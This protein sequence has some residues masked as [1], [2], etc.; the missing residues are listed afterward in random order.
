[1]RRKQYFFLGIALVLLGFIIVPIGALL[2][3]SS[4]VERMIVLLGLSTILIIIGVIFVVSSKSFPIGRIT[5][6]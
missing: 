3:D 4:E 1:M 2:F 5:C 6:L